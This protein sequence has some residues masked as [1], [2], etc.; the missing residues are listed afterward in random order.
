MTCFDLPREEGRKSRKRR[1]PPDVLAVLKLKIVYSM[2]VDTTKD[3]LK[4][5]LFFPRR[6][7]G[8]TAKT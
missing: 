7:G 5:R 4:S 6:P 2:Q 3:I 1:E 8:K